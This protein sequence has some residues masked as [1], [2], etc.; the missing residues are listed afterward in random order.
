MEPLFPEIEKR[1]KERQDKNIQTEDSTKDKVSYYE[2]RLSL[3]YKLILKQGTNTYV[4]MVKLNNDN[5]VEYAELDA[6]V[7]KNSSLPAS[8]SQKAPYQTANSSIYNSP[9]A[10]DPL[11][12]PPNDYYF[13]DP[14]NPPTYRSVGRAGMTYEP[15]QQALCIW[16]SKPP[17]TDT[18][19]GY[20]YVCFVNGGTTGSYTNLNGAPLEDLWWLSKIQAAN[21]W[22]IST[23]NKNI[24]VAVIDSGVDFTHPDLSA[25]MWVNPV[26]GSH[27]YNFVDNNNNPMD[28]AG[29]GT[30]AAGIIGA[31]GNNTIGIAGVNWIIS[32]MALKVSD[33]MST[34]ASA[35][36]YAVDHG[37]RII[38][39]SFYYRS[40]YHILADAIKYAYDKGCVIVAEAGDNDEDVLNNYPANLNEVIAVSESTPDDNIANI[41]NFGV[42]IDVAAPGVGILTTTRVGGG[43]C[44]LKKDYTVDVGTLVA[45]PIVSGLAAL[46]LSTNPNLTNEEVRQIIRHNADD[47]LAP[48]WDPYSGYGRINAYRSLLNE[49]V[50]VA[51]I[52]TPENWD[53]ISKSV[54]I[55]GTAAD[56]S[57]NP[58]DK[59]KLTFWKYDLSY[60]EGIN[61]SESDFTVFKTSYT[62]INNNYLIKNWN[63]ANIK[64]GNY[65]IRLRTYGLSFTGGCA[66][67]TKTFEDRIYVTIAPPYSGAPIAYVNFTHGNVS[68]IDSGTDAE[69]ARIPIEGTHNIAITPDNLRAY[70]SIRTY[71]YTE[72]AVDVIDTLQNKII[73]AIPVDAEAFGI[74]VSPDGTRVYVVCSQTS[75]SLDI[76]DAVPSSPTYNTVIGSIQNISDQPATPGAGWANPAF[77]HDGKRLYLIDASDTIYIIDTDPS[78][79]T[80]NTVLRNISLPSGSYAP[81]HTVIIVSDDDNELF[82]NSN[83]G[84]VTVVNVGVPEGF[85]SPFTL[86]PA[87]TVSSIALTPDNN[88]LYAILGNA[89]SPVTLL[90]HTT[91]IT[92][93]AFIPGTSFNTVTAPDR[94]LRLIG[95]MPTCRI[96]KAYSFSEETYPPYTP[97]IGSTINTSANQI[98]NQFPVAGQVADTIAFQRD[99]PDI[100]MVAVSPDNSDPTVPHTISVVVTDNIALIRQVNLYYSVND[101][102]FI[103]IPMTRG[104]VYNTTVNGTPAGYYYNAIVPAQA[105][106]SKIKFYIQASDS[107]GRTSQD[108]LPCSPRNFYEINQDTCGEN[109]IDAPIIP[110]GCGFS[111][112]TINWTYNTSGTFSWIGASPS[113]AIG[114]PGIIYLAGGWWNIFALNMFGSLLWSYNTGYF[115]SFAGPVALI[116][117]TTYA[118]SWDPYATDGRIYA[119]DSLTGM[120]KWK[121]EIGQA[122]NL[123]IGNDGTVYV[124]SNQGLFA[125]L[126]NGTLKWKLSITGSFV[127]IGSDGTIY[128]SGGDKLYALNSDGSIKWS[129]LMKPSFSVQGLAIGDNNNLYLNA[130]NSD[131]KISCIYSLSPSGVIEW[132]DTYKGL[133]GGSPV[134]G[135]DR[136]LYIGTIQNNGGRTYAFDNAGS[137]KWIFG[138]TYSMRQPPTLGANDMIYQGTFSTNT[139]YPYNGCLYA[140]DADGNPVWSVSTTGGISG[141]PDIAPDG[142]IYFGTVIDTGSG[143]VY[144]V[145]S[146]SGGLATSPWPKQWHDAV[147]SSRGGAPIYLP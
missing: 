109:I 78:S 122:S 113:I 22:T 34:I 85:I 134:I 66:P 71:N 142:T 132:V 121:Q 114:S 65:T 45:T 47:I 91:Y 64:P 131:A 101:G 32:I 119:L 83:L 98:V 49:R 116:T 8:S 118:A 144:S 28:Y 38:N 56:L 62:P 44:A 52:G 110:V 53:L 74:A 130:T 58:E 123:A 117:G 87:T 7:A 46:I 86:F 146:N 36:A 1:V 103:Q 63:I 111:Q 54:D 77:S 93:G 11:P 140:L 27:G 129:F 31:V 30:N 108:P 139:S 15:S 41:S 126:P 76:I 16:L 60:G 135:S 136:S 79:P 102:N 37:A 81:R 127:S 100:S 82:I 55:I 138:S 21:A 42:K 29:S 5:R 145:Q 95:V 12:P 107:I 104:I 90:P 59:S 105:Y 124:N 84:G 128:Y 9:V 80:Y 143:M 75:T 125:F 3:I 96:N 112:G 68:G 97:I 57:N 4:T 20:P 39:I 43:C 48:G 2:T 99:F 147:N 88:T 70:V 61:P 89:I 40:Y 35:I 10:S 120:L 13:Y 115:E 51:H 33:Q 92:E 106:G 69:I 6:I 141:A 133:A 72:P 94:F 73:D 14:N 18:Y 17:C 25:N 19:Y 26:D 50:L 137:L 23:G 67:I 24:I